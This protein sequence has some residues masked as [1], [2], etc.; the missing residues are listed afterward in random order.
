MYSTKSDAIKLFPRWSDRFKSMYFKNNS[1]SSSQRFAELMRFE[2]L[3]ISSAERFM[4]LKLK[5]TLHLRMQL[6]KRWVH[7]ARSTPFTDCF[8]IFPKVSS[9]S[10]F[11]LDVPNVVNPFLILFKIFQLQLIYF[12]LVLRIF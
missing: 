7:V 8:E 12:Q 5:S 9:I 11:S 4:I 1:H 2:L 3:I 10:N 6:F